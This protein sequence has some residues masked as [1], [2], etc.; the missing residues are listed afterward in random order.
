MAA[1]Y[2]T[3]APSARL[4]SGRKRI[5]RVRVFELQRA[6]LIAGMI[7]TVADV[8]YPNATVGSVIA[9]ARVSRKTF[10]D[11]FDDREDCF[12]AAFE[13]TLNDARGQVTDACQAES[14][15]QKGVRAALGSLLSFMEEE[16]ALARLC[17]VDALLAGPA[18]TERR[19]EVLDEL[20][21]AIERGRSARAAAMTLRTSPPKA[22]S[23][24]FSRCSTCA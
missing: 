7:G 11:V 22:W 4:N 12:L 15:W 6:R 18:V 13:Q 2:R 24:R 17:M 9:R 3:R 5:P 16:P 8:G 20:A 23:V 19:I 14:N 1:T 21:A 10:Y